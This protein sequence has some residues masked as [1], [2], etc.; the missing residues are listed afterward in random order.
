MGWGIDKAP[1]ITTIKLVVG[2]IW[3]TQ[4]PSF[5]KIGRQVTIAVGIALTFPQNYARLSCPHCAQHYK[6]GAYLNF[7][8]PRN[9]EIRNNE[10]TVYN[11]D[12]QTIVIMHY[13]QTWG[14]CEVVFGASV[15]RFYLSDWV[16]PGSQELNYI[17]CDHD[18]YDTSE[19][20]RHLDKHYNEHRYEQGTVGN[21]V[22]NNLDLYK[23]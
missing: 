2:V 23:T 18:Y 11:L 20:Y 9:N 13:K 6:K 7:K 4:S 12:T 21:H 19:F 1:S 22:Q 3:E 14:S 17:H 5:T 16:S 15:R 8:S 10:V